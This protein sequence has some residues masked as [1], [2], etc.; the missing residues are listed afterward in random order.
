VAGLVVG[1]GGLGRLLFAVPAGGAASSLGDRRVLLLGAAIVAIAAA[2]GAFGASLFVLTLVTATIGAGTAFWQLGRYVLVS[3]AAPHAQR[4]RALS[5]IGGMNRIGLFIGPAVGAVVASTAGLA[6]AFAVQAIAA[7]LAVAVAMTALGSPAA[8]VPPT[9]GRFPRR[10]ARAAI[11]NR[12]S[13]VRAAPPIVILGLLRQSRHVFLPLWGAAIGLGVV[14]IGLVTTLSFL[15]DAALFYPVGAVMDRVGRKVVSVPCLALLA[16]SFI[17]LPFAGDAPS[18]ALV[19]VLSGLGNGLG[20]G[21]VLTLGADLAP[22]THRGEFLGV[23]HLVSDTG[24]VAGPLVSSAATGLVGLGAAALIV[25]AIGLA[26][27]AMLAVLV[28][29]TREPGPSAGRRSGSGPGGRPG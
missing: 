2:V 5:T 18:Y 29:E 13:L 27:A 28:A 6:A 15:I 9:E 8:A 19:G 26:G 10:L 3:G 23:W 14:E 22:R 24:Q 20:A 17:V 4:G 12:A 21:L 16:M 25:G 11:D 1:A 7:L